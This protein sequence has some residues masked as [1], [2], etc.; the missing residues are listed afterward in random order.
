MHTY[1]LLCSVSGHVCVDCHARG[2]IVK[3]KK[4][5]G[6]KRILDGRTA[7]FRL[8]A[9]EFAAGRRLGLLTAVR[10]VRRCAVEH[11][12]EPPF[13]EGQEVYLNAYDLEP[14]PAV[15][16]NDVAQ[17]TARWEEVERRAHANAPEDFY[18]VK[19]AEQEGPLP[20]RNIRAGLE[21]VAQW[22]PL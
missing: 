10:S 22:R 1:P 7:R 19:L 17:H 13:V 15:I 5:K 12:R 2:F 21:L 20:V 6:D 16:P 14:E 11:G 3:D 9:A 18:K 4:A 8:R